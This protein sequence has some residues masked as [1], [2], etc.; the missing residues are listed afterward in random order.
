VQGSRLYSSWQEAR[1]LL[2]LFV[3]EKALYELRYELTSRPAWT[4]IPLRGILGYLG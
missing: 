3:L 4:R 2:N 1:S